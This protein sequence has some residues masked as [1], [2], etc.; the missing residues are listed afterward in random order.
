MITITSMF[1]SAKNVRKE[2][3]SRWPTQICVAQRPVTST[4]RCMYTYIYIYICMYVCIYIYIYIFL[5]VPCTQL[6]LAGAVH[7]FCIRPLLCR[8]PAAGCQIAVSQTTQLHLG[9]QR[10][11]CIMRS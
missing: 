8:T 6:P 1:F 9:V 2:A 10:I 7:A 11:E 5:S 4:I 3:G